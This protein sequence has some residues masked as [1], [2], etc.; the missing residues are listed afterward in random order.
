MPKNKTKKL[1][2]HNKAGSE[3]KTY[4][5]HLGKLCRKKEHKRKERYCIKKVHYPKSITVCSQHY[6]PT[7]DSIG[8]YI[9]MLERVS[10]TAERKGEMTTDS[11]EAA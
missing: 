1:G 3:R 4:N 8:S 6:T 11:S 7:Q 5:S 10:L 2:G 9:M